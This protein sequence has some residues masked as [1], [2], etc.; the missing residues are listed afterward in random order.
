MKILSV[1]AELLHVAEGSQADMT[2]LIVFFQILRKPL[3]MSVVSSGTMLTQ[4]RSILAACKGGLYR[5]TLELY[6]I[7]HS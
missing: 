5:K 3:K 4:F 2:K 7:N 1:G 6:V